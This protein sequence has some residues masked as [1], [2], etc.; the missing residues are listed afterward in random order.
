MS[1]SQPGA[2]LA[3]SPSRSP[4]PCAVRLATPSAALILKSSQSRVETW[5]T[6]PERYGPPSTGCIN[7]CRTQRTANS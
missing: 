1:L 2:L 4:A 6:S 5:F 7:E 3:L